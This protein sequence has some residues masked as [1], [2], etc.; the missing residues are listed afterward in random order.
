MTDGPATSGRPPGARESG[1]IHVLDLY[2]VLE[3][4]PHASYDVIHAAYRVLARSSHP[5]RNATLDGAQTMRRLNAAYEV[6]KDPE[7]RARYDLEC[8][9]ARRSVRSLA[10]PAEYAMVPVRSAQARMRTPQVVDLPVEPRRPILSPQFVFVVGMVVVVMIMLLFVGWIS[11][12]MMPT[13]DVP[14]VR[15]NETPPVRLNSVVKPPS[16]P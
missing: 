8:L 3:V 4:S 6:L 13:A 10:A 16:G 14:A 9:R 2:E 15:L 11:M 7:R 1:G 5:D 12:E